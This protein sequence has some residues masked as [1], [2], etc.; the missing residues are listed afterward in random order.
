MVVRKTKEI[1]YAV[2]SDQKFATLVA[3]AEK[4]S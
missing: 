2:A 4:S 1:P 3:L